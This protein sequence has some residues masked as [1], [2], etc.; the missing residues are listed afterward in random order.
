M[1][2]PVGISA[3]VLGDKVRFDGGHKRSRFA[4]E[5]LNSYVKFV[6]ICPE[7][8]IGMPVPRQTIRLLQHEEQIR[9]V[10][11][12]DASVDFTDQMTEFAQAQ[13]ERLQH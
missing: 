7:V 12:K 10:A 4:A 3:C 5:E 1:D 2:I 11:T 9:L 8:G 6:P 13:V